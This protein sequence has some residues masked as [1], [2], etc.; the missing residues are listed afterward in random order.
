[1]P[2]ERNRIPWSDLVKHIING[3]PVPQTGDEG[4]IR[5]IDN[6]WIDHGDPMYPWTAGVGAG[7]FE[8]QSTDSIMAASN[9]QSAELDSA[10]GPT[11][12]AV[13]MS[14]ASSN[15]DP[16]KGSDSYGPGNIGRN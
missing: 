3:R 8:G 4:I 9:A 1:M 5:D 10:A 6:E 12:D 2:T 7:T 11:G 15:T 13:E 14:S 16:G